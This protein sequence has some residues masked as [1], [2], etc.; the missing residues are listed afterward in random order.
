[1][2]LLDKLESLGRKDALRLV[3]FHLGSQI[4]DIQYIKAALEEV[5]SF[6]R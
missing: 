3:H 5:G 1:M 6:L 4:T 2:K